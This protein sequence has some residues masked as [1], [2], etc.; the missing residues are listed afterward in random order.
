MALVTAFTRAIVLAD[1]QFLK[2]NVDELFQSNTEARN[3]M[4]RCVKVVLLLRYL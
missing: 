2:L 1:E 3:Q 4:S